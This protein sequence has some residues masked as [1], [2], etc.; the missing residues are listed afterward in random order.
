MADSPSEQ[1]DGTPRSPSPPPRTAVTVVR[2]PRPGQTPAVLARVQR[3]ARLYVVRSQWLEVVG[4]TERAVREAAAAAPAGQAAVE[5]DP[6]ELTALKAHSAVPQ[7]TARAALLELQ[8]A[9]D[10]T[11]GGAAKEGAVPVDVAVARLS[12]HAPRPLP[13]SLPA[14]AAPDDDDSDEDETLAPSDEAGARPPHPVTAQCC[15]VVCSHAPASRTRWHSPS[16]TLPD[17][18]RR[19]WSLCRPDSA[20]GAGVTR[21][22]SHSTSPEL[23]SATLN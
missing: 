21:A 22:H 11:R 2:L 17:A 4:G 14:Q 15:A 16:S 20:R 18:A 8:F 6:A 7:R 5:A 3:D 23:V 9:A 1:S 13:A 19:C 12:F 10:S